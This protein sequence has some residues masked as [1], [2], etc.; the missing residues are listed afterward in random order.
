MR[1][2]LGFGVVA[3]AVA[4]WLLLAGSASAAGEIVITID[5]NS[6][7]E[8]GS[9]INLVDYEVPAEYVGRTCSAS[10]LVENNGSVHPKNDLIITTA[11]NEYVFEN[12]ETEPGQTTIGG[13]EVPIGDRIVVDLRFGDDGRSSSELVLTFDCEE[14]PPET[15]T[16]VTE[17]TTTAPPETTVVPPTSVSPETTVPAPS[18][19]VPTSVAPQ[20]TVPPSTTVPGTAPAPQPPSYTG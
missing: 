19:T 2:G 17:T 5:D 14:P 4:I 7:G 1:K 20:T 8:T 10:L 3:A 13:G 16:T 12:F 18:T 9:I 6:R 15:T 11:G